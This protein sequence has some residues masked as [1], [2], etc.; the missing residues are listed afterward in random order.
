M[1]YLI[2]L[3]F[4]AVMYVFIPELEMQKQMELYEASLVYRVSSRAARAM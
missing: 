4:S 1:V 3:K 2:K